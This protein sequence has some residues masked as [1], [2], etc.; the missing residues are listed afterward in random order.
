MTKIIFIYSESDKKIGKI[1]FGKERKISVEVFDENYHWLKGKINEVL[2]N[3]EFLC[4]DNEA[5]FNRLSVLKKA[6]SK[7]NLPLV[8]REMLVKLGLDV[9]LTTE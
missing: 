4:S 5:P 7:H 8:I 6:E 2:E 9:E 3:P 1:V